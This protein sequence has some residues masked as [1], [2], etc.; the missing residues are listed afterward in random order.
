MSPRAASSGQDNPGSDEFSF[1]L[2]WW[3]L[4]IWIL[5][6]RVLWLSVNFK[7][8][9]RMYALLKW[10]WWAYWSLANDFLPGF[11]ENASTTCTWQR[12]EILVQSSEK[13]FLHWESPAVCSLRSLARTRQAEVRETTQIRNMLQLQ[14]KAEW[15]SPFCSLVHISPTW[16]S[17]TL[18]APSKNQERREQDIDC[19]HLL[20]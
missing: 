8:C 1:Y 7:D 18:E 20:G 9:I 17:G 2:S 12:E 5:P 16:Q 4:S 10:I 13:L 15:L 3:C 6:S 11:N 19:L 14:C